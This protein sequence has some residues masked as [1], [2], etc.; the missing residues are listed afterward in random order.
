[1]KANSSSSA[2]SKFTSGS[3]R[4]PL[5]ATAAAILFSAPVLLGQTG[6]THTL[7]TTVIEA[8][9]VPFI[10]QPFLPPVQGVKINAGTKT[11]VIDLDAF[12][13]ITNNN[14]RQAL[15][16][17]PGLYLSEETTPLLSLGYRGL[18]PSRVQFTQ[19]LK[20][21]IPIHAD[22]FG[23]PEAYYTPPLDTVDRIEFLRGG[24]ALQYGPQPGG[25]LNFVTHRPRA[26]VPFAGGTTNVFGSGNMFS[27]FSYFSGTT[28]LLR[29]LQSPKRRRIPDD[30]QQFQSEC[31][32]V[33]AGTRRKHE[34]PVDPR[35][36]RL[37]GGS[38]RAGR[39][40]FRH[41]QEPRELQRRSQCDLTAVR[42]A[43]AAPL[44]GI[45]PVGA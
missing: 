20:D 36:R 5:I 19:V 18:D 31:G 14:Y 23:Y 43:Q 38:R 26:D 44:R 22:Q 3:P 34:Q 40:D 12:P 41:R 28:G 32:A 16:K 42:P 15:A 7:D 8:E 6:T 4:N 10:Q 17:T 35:A 25:A 33:E 30:E 24:A 1:M 13:L 45:A 27:N 29:L 11:S 37:R 39:P 9:G 2:L 21:G